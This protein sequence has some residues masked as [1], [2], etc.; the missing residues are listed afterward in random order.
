MATPPKMP[1]P[2]HDY[3]DERTREQRQRER[4]EVVKQAASLL[5]LAT[6]DAE[7][8]RI[9]G[10]IRERRA[11]AP[12]S[13]QVELVPRADGPD[14]VAAS[15]RLLIRERDL[16][17][18]REVL[19]RLGITE[20]GRTGNVTLLDV[21]A[22]A[23]PDGIAALAAR[24]RK[25]GAPVSVDHVAPLGAWMKGEGGPEPTTGARRFPAVEFP[26]KSPPPAIAVLD[27]GISNAGRTDGYLG[28]NIA[29]ADV[30][31][32]DIF[33]TLGLLDAD[34]G[35][36]S[37]VVGIVQQ[38]V[39]PA[40]IGS[41]RVADSDGIT[42]SFDVADK[43]RLAVRQGA[44]ILNLSLGTATEDGNPPIALQDVVDELLQDN[45]EVLIVCAAGNDASTTKVWPAAFAETH[46]NVVAVAALDAAGAPAP[47]SSH[48]RWVTCSTIGEGVA[49]TYVVGTE[50]G[51]LIGDPTPDTFHPPNPWAVWSGTSFAAPQIAGAVARICSQ[52]VGVGPRQA[53]KLL[54]AD[55]TPA[56][57]GSPYGWTVE[58]LPG[59]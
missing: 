43:M 23:A 1:F 3:P 13:V 33:P 28:A 58:I 21:P 39:P 32:L 20:A 54:E 4:R 59:T 53:L 41:Y 36:G 57:A 11:G 8:R 18:N 40:A 17:A 27:S 19:R 51:P 35:H 22:G 15:G 34:A 6:D 12:R 47:W 55:A 52:N 16:A 37:S 44:M 46:P 7:R 56:A 29:P 48:G 50:D 30:D 9:V 10:R 14:L 31:P 38:V 24:I 42:T 25:D 2:T 49:S 45:P 26:Q 5:R